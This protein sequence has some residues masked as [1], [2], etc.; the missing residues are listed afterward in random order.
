[1]N[2]IY[3]FSYK[4]NTMTAS[5]LTIVLSSRKFWALVTAL[6]AIGSAFVNQQI[7]GT[8]AISSCVTALAAYMIATGIED[9]N[10][11]R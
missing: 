9:T 10:L 8:E 11:S 2:P 6:V 4:E 5:K 1:M 3:K 7:I